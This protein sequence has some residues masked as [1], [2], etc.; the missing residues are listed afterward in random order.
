MDQCPVVPGTPETS[1][2]N[3][4]SNREGTER[5]HK[6]IWVSLILPLLRFCRQCKRGAEKRGDD[7]VVVN[8]SKGGGSFHRR[9]TMKKEK[10]KPF[11][12]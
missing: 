12:N 9:K 5:S 4:K 11:E 8:G 10:K 7:F 6:A 1:N 3:I 2:R